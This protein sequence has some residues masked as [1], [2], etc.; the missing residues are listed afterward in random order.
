MMT[1][2][3]GKIIRTRFCNR[4]RHGGKDCVGEA[5]ETEACN[6]DL[7]WV[8]SWLDICKEGTCDKFFFF[9]KPKNVKCTVCHM[10]PYN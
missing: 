9:I 2:G 4:N 7:C 1:C 3:G 8:D 10:I 6:T 5:E